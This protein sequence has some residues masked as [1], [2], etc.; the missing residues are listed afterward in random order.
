MAQKTHQQNISG[1]FWKIA[2]MTF[3]IQGRIPHIGFG[4]WIFDYFPKW[5]TLTYLYYYYCILIIYCDTPTYFVLFV[6]ASFFHS[7]ILILLMFFLW[8]SLFICLLLYY[9]C[10]LHEIFLKISKISSVFYT[11]LNKLI[12]WNWKKRWLNMTFTQNHHSMLVEI[13]NK[14]V[15]FFFKSSGM[16]LKIQK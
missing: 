16:L 3:E 4:L 8:I 14:K 15:I 13:L 11:I 7:I 6:F 10:T 12:V 1:K 5:W 9:L 2:L